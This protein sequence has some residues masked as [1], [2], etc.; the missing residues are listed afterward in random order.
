MPSFPQNKT[1]LIDAIEKNYEKLKFEFK[2]IPEN[3]ATE[4]S[5]DEQI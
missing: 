1:E 3:L 5:M 4:K 2:N